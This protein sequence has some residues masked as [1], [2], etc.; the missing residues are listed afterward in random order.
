MVVYGEDEKHCNYE[1]N[2]IDEV[3]LCCDCDL[4]YDDGDLQCHK[5]LLLGP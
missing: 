3:K 2:G 5:N 4:C 1:I